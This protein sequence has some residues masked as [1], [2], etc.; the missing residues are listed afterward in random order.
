MLE[1]LLLLPELLNVPVLREELK[2]PE[3]RLIV[4]GLLV[5][6]IVLLLRGVVPN[7][8]LLRD[9]PNL[10]ELRFIVLLFLIV[11]L[12]LFIV[13]LFLLELLNVPPVREFLNEP[14]LFKLLLRNVPD[15]VFLF[16]LLLLLL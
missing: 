8:P 1:L 10:F 2:L 5:L 12:L 11:L 7:D 15:D 14:E 16:T 3:L 13:P 6:F 9:A 4:A